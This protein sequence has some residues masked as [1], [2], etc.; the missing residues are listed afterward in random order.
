MLHVIAEVADVSQPLQPQRA[1]LTMQ[2]NFG[3]LWC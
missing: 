1:A 2:H 3:M